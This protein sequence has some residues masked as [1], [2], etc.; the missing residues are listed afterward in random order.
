MKKSGQAPF[1]FTFCEDLHAVPQKA[2]DLEI[3]LHGGFAVDRRPGHG[4]A[5]YGMPGHGLIKISP[6]LTGQET[7]E[8][9]G[10]LKPLNFHSTKLGTFDGEPRLFLPANEDALVAVLTLDG[11]LEY[12]FR[13]PEF[14]EYRRE[15]VAFR[16]TDTAL[17]GNQ[18]FVA[19]GYGANY[20]SCADLSERKW[21]AIFGG[22]TDDP[23]ELG[24]FGTAHGLN[25]V[26]D[27]D[28]LAIADRPHSRFE[29]ASY[30]GKVSM[31]HALP[32]G[33]KPCGIDY[34]HHGGKWHAVVGS[35][36]DPL[37]GRP[38]P[39]Y[40]LD[41]ETYE[42]LSTVRPKEDLGIERADH[43]HNAV[44]YEYGGDTYL[45]CQSW[46]PGYY[47]VLKMEA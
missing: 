34:A 30:Q 37:E 39:I 7:I 40:I 1:V 15:G 18:L 14:D 2:L 3:K 44:W 9:P 29:L 16:P 25:R 43:I 33:S 12:V 20:I 42:V 23:E 35:L 4:H 45:L 8:L 47:F 19:D 46:N 41:A 6:D 17:V 24:K 28:L 36:D 21:T 5:Y 11:E 13:S 22:K 10:E 32:R 26:P 31:S 27:A 38:A